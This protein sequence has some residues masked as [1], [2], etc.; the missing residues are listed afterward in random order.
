MKKNY[1][2]KT[3]NGPADAFLTLKILCAV[4]SSSIAPHL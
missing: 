4:Y 3:K 2:I 1:N